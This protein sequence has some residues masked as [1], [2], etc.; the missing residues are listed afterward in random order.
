MSS[1]DC[2]CGG[3][4]SIGKSEVLVFSD[5]HF[6]PFYDLQLFNRLNAADPNQWEGIFESATVTTPSI[7]GADTNYPLFKLALASIVKISVQAR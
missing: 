3:G 5:V 6:D 2:G 4:S 7:P 1:R